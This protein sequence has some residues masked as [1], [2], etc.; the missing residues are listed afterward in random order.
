MLFRSICLQ[1]GGQIGGAGEDDGRGYD[2]RDWTYPALVGDSVP[3]KFV[4]YASPMHAE[5]QAAL[6]GIDLPSSH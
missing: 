5:N 6:C 2:A 4:T 1:V 3:D